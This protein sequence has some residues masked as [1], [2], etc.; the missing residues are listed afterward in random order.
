[1]VSYVVIT[2]IQINA[3][4]ILRVCPMKKI[5][6]LFSILLF[7]Y[8]FSYPVYADST[9]KVGIYNNEPLIFIDTDGKGKGIFADII[10]YVASKE[11][12]QI[13]YVAGTWQQCLSRLE[14]NQID[15]LCTIAFSKDR[16][17]RY[18]F[19]K[20]NLLTNWGQ[21]YT[22]KNSHIKAVTE[23]AGR[24]VAVLNGDI[25]YDIFNKIIKEFGIKC[26]II[27]TDDYSAVMD[28]I[29]RNKADAGV[30]NR[31]FG[32]KYGKRYNIDKSGV[33][34]NPI[35]IHFAVPK[36]KNHEIIAAIDRHTILLKNEEGSVYYRSLEKWFGAVSEKWT[37][38]LWGK[39]GIAGIFGIVI[40]LFLGSLVLKSR[41]KNKTSEL[42]MELAHRRQTEEKLKEAYNIINR[43][44]VVAFLWKNVKEWP[45]E[46]VSDNA[47]DLFGYSMEEFTSGQVSYAKA[48]HPDDLNRVVKEVLTFRKNKLRTNFTHKPYR[49]IT[50][51]GTIKWVNHRTYMR[52]DD[53]G[54]ITHYE[55]VVVDITDRKQAE[56]DLR[57]SE[58]KYR[59]IL[60][61]IDDG[62]YEV[63]IAGNFTFFNDSM[64][65]M[66]G[67]PR[68]EL[69]GMN[70]REYM[71]KKNAAKIH[72]TFNKVYQTG[73]STKALDW[74]LLRKDGSLCF[75][76]TI[77][78]LITDSN[79]KK[80][81]F[82]G[83]ARDIT[84]RKQLEDQ[85]R[86]A[87]KMES[88][89]TLAGG[90]AH[91][92]NNILYMIIGNTELALQNTPEWN[93]NHTNLEKIKAASLRAA[94]IVKQLLNFSRKTDQ[95]LKPVDLI[96]VIKDA[97]EFLRSSIPATIE[98][99]KNITAG[100]IT[101][102]ADPIQINQV[103]M[104][105]CINASQ[106]MEETD[107]ILEIN[108]ENISRT[109]NWAIRYP[110]LTAGD[111]VKITISDTGPGI[112]PE[113]ID[114]IF[115]PYFTTK[116]IGKGS[117][118]GLAVVQGIIN[119][120]NGAITIDSRPG[121]GTIFSILFPI[122]DEKPEVE[123]TITD[124]L[125]CGIE[126]I[127]FVDDEESIADVTGQI[128][129]QLGYTVQTQTSP[130]D[131]LKLFQSKP[132]DFDLVIT[133]MTM[134]QMNGIK[135]SEKLMGIRSDIPVII[136]TGHSSLIDEE[137]AGQIGIA[138]YV[139]KPVSMSKIA[140]TIRKILDK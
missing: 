25:H 66:L 109:A 32:T 114:R 62:Y 31:F 65:R 131:A 79:D 89:G 119:N 137:K 82:R 122:I 94:G 77:V 78:S 61:N 93:P 4:I 118:M 59:N 57:Q 106:A 112:E 11:G 129:E 133:D 27:E 64:C 123:T 80:I 135:L 91:D 125:P 41:V 128:L 49:I 52:R 44:P 113:V 60:K 10:E 12:W 19:N 111:Y 126:T 127:L 17:K 103:M 36:G 139:T 16:N 72:Q 43:S 69:I 13:K 15:I 110:G 26:Q 6:V 5:I 51:K 8:G 136:C 115:D 48:V 38:P 140:K 14:N 3:T 67:Y 98:I 70:N 34:F 116:E 100:E 42:T 21:L 105:I 117:G 54:K 68:D 120:H 23:L 97:L 18:D 63:D 1:M 45:I 40:F 7:Q 138:A 47:I 73:I 121:K 56:E 86:Q 87:L 46:F 108:V 84:D 55:G 30:V 88:I 39:W 2:L 81:G 90:I 130:Q 92:F 29:S 96:T 35:K 28:L 58:E 75:V 9:I 104:N 24:K 134:P 74:K 101:I 37:F 20:K 107:G 99:R 102:L 71:D 95:K 83:I 76:E 85:L 53:E 124:D 22:A 33:I 132:S 50:K